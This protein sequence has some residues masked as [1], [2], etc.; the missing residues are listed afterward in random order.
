M[1]EINIKTLVIIFMLPSIAF[2]AWNTNE[3]MRREHS[4]IRP[5]HGSGSSLNNWNLMGSA[6]A[7]DSFIR[8]TPDARSAQ[9]GIWN[10]SPCFS[11]NWEMEVH[12]KVHGRGTDLFGDGFAI[13]YVRDP[14]QCPGRPECSVFGNNDYFVGLGVILDTYNNYNGAH[15][16]EHPYISAMVNNGTLHYDHDRD[17]THTQMAGCTAKLRGREHDTHIK[18]KYYEDTVTVYTDVENRRAWSECMRADGVVLP[19]SYYF[20]LTAATGDLTDNHEIYS[21]RMYD[22]DAPEPLSGGEGEVD[23]S[24]VM[25]SASFFEAPRDHV[26]DPKPSLMGGF[27]KLLLVLVGVVV[28]CGA[29][30]IGGIFYVKQNEESRKRLY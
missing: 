28:V 21:V 5:F 27:K 29:V 18:I 16:H 22:L 7:S 23:R 9:G 10:K 19:T 30:F 25:P 3:Y 26:E 2:S 4:L 20:G 24:K 13:W 15:N 17:G 11:R 8:L 14:S 1:E 6:F 12:F